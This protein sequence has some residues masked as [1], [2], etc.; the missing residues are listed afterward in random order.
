MIIY[1]KYSGQTSSETPCLK[2]HVNASQ[3]PERPKT[4]KQLPT[5]DDANLRRKTDP[6][7]KK[8]Q[9]KPSPEESATPRTHHTPSKS[10]GE[11]NNILLHRIHHSPHPSQIAKYSYQQITE[12]V[13]SML[14]PPQCIIRTWKHENVPAL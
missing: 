4:H 11:Q 10:K 3:L 6:V 5:V 14:N 12:H 2:Y 8:M 9:H 13:E 7:P 1:G